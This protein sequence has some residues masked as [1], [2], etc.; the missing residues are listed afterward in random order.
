MKTFYLLAA[1]AS[2]SLLSISCGEDNGDCP[3]GTYDTLS[4]CI[5]GKIAAGDPDYCDCQTDNWPDGPWYMV[6]EYD[7]DCIPGT[8]NSYQDCENARINAGNSIDNDCQCVAIDPSS[9][10]WYMVD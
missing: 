6:E 5:Q 10:P 3:D 9:G 7:N 2:L 4:E 1:L 8:W